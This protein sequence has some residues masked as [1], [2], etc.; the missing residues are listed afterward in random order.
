MGH[1]VR[2]RGLEYG[3]G[4]TDESTTA[5]V[6]AHATGEWK[7]AALAELNAILRREDKAQRALP[8]LRSV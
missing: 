2:A 7:T 1:R 5:R 6:Y 4:M 8:G 3:G